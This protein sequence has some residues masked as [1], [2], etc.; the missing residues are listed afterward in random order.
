MAEDGSDPVRPND[1]RGMFRILED[2]SGAADLTRF[3][4]LLRDA[5]ARH[6]GWRGVSVLA[7][8]TVDSL[9]DD[10]PGT[11]HFGVSYVDE[12][13]E[14]WWSADPLVSLQAVRALNSRGLVALRDLA[15]PEP[16]QGYLGTFLR[17]FDVVDIV[18]VAVDAGAGGIGYLGVPSIGAPSGARERVMLHKLRRQLGPHFEQ[19][20]LALRRSDHTG[21]LTP[22]EREVGD[23]VVRGY[24]NEQIARR[25]S[26]G[27]DTVKKHVSRLLVK[28][29]TRSRTQFTAT[30]LG[31]G[32]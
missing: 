5:F 26:I 6:L 15:I 7:G 16:Q 31:P 23:L 28:T 11:D 20:L 27:L 24:S 12:Y 4:D 32:R 29:G 8:A 21:G 19:H 3:Q 30:W 25:L 17:R 1:Y 14:R 18:G 13:R 22:R 9:T 2:V 10:R